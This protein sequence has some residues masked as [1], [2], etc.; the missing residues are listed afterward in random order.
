MTKEGCMIFVGDDWAED[1]HDVHLMDESGTRLASRRLPEGLAGIGEFHQLLA[2]HAEEP[3]EIVIGIET[4]RGL[5]VTAL[6]GVG[7]RVYAINPLAAARYRDR[8]HV[9]GAKS[10]AGDAK[11][12]ADLVRTDRHNHH[13]VAGDSADA[14]A[15]KVLARAHQNLIW[16][17]NR[18]TN[19]LRSALR[20]YY[21]A[22]LEAFNDLHDR[23]AL[24][25]LGRAPTPVQAA[26]LSLSKIRSALKAAGRQRNLDVR[27][28]EIQTA[29]RTEQL[30]APSA[31][32][33]AFAATTRATIGIIAELNHQ[34]NDLEAEL[35]THF[36][37]HPDADIYL[38]L[39]GLGVILGARVLGEFGD[40]PNR[41]TDAKCR[42]NY[43]GTSPLTVA[44][45]KKRA[46]LARHIR[47]RRLY[48]A[49][50]QWA[51][52]AINAS[53]GARAFY[54]ARRTAGDLHHQALRALGN[55]LV[56]ILHG[57]LRHRTHYN[58]DK[59]WA[60]RQT[61]PDTRAA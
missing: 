45:G 10:D 46:V 35:A 32:T 16:T 18:H 22:A 43:A 1:H 20:E 5:W 11:L 37:T 54:D 53:A 28:Q 4:D 57:C 61:N 52:C 23:D 7:Y 31:V 55:R 34:I 56:G 2:R 38:S 9:S 59:A 21:P 48:D 58:E 15:V 17:R 47:N 60:H 42:K 50:D 41:Y 51:F 13:R 40:D 6:V 27:S 25:V 39:P 8:H 26:N 44:S 30:A 19:T 14:E 24:A 3:D 33:T 12:L 29:L 49:I 36:E